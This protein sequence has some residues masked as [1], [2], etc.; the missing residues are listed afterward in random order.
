MYGRLWIAALVE[1]TS[2]NF[3]KCSKIMNNALMFSKASDEWAT[4]QD[5]YIALNLE[6][7]FQWDVAARRENSKTGIH[8]YFGLDHWNPRYQDALAEK[9][10]WIT[11]DRRRL[12]LNPPYSKCHA[13]VAKAANAIK[14]GLNDTCI[15]CLLP[16]RTDTR[17]FHEHVW[18]NVR[19]HARPGIEVRLIKGR[20][21]FGDASNSAPFP[22]MVVI[23][24]SV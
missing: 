10:N 23:F 3:H 13:F 19:H 12:F 18:D 1:V 6:F 22:S 11:L 15:V 20:L 4:P 2:R 16:A 5:F 17:W 24:S 14:L 8:A 7:Q 21:R 9:L